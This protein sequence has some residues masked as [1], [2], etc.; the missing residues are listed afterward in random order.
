MN[1]N[2]FVNESKEYTIKYLDSHGKMISG[3]G[4]KYKSSGDAIADAKQKAPKDAVS[5]N[6]YVMKG[7]NSNSLIDT[8]TL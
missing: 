3:F 2:Q 6:V 1:F 7:K 8:I 5:I 4:Y